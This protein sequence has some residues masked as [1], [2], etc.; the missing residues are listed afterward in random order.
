MGYKVILFSLA[1][2]LTSNLLFSQN[3]EW[4]NYTN[5]QIVFSLADEGN[6]LWVGTIG[7]LVKLDK[8]TGQM[9]FFNSANG[10]PDNWVNAI[11]IDQQGNKWIG[12]SG[13]GLAKF[14]GINWTVYKSWNSGL[15]TNWV[16]SIAIDE[17]GNKWIGT[18]GGLGVYREGGVLKVEEKSNEI[19]KEFALYQNYPN[20]FN[21][22]TTIEFDLPERS[23]VRLVVYD[24]LGR[25]VEK[26]V[27]GELDAGRYRVDFNTI[28]LSS[29]VY[30][31]I[32][33]DGKFRDVKKMVLVR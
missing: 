25:E 13:G 32:L 11:A 10:L 18:D 17:Y 24:A 31:Y 26:L 19:P 7:G 29:G 5:G 4:I 12:T 8:S 14:D 28:N 2:V 30:F 16:Y 22:T 1:L 23:S 9:Q 33:D 21:P 6:H 27:D 20:P 15:P 3:P